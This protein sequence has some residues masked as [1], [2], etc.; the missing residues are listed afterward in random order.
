MSLEL[1]PVP[2]KI[3]PETLAILR[4]ES[5]I[6]GKHLNEVAREVLQAWA[7][8][9]IHIASVRDKHLK[10]DGFEGIGGNVTK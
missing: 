3:A 8:R 5:E 4:S 6:T 9:Q 1:I 2:I 10:R 7:D